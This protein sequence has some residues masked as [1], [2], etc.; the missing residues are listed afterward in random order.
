[1]R[2]ILDKLLTPTVAAV[3]LVV[4]M[5]FSY[6]VGKWAGYREGVRYGILYKG[7]E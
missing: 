1:M 3:S 5:A 7:C 6:V 4:I 2:K